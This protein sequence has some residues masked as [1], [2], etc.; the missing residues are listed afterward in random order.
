[1]WH[2]QIICRNNKSYYDHISS[3]FSHISLFHMLYE[4]R[5]CGGLFMYHKLSCVACV[6]VYAKSSYNSWN[7]NYVCFFSPVYDFCGLHWFLFREYRF[8]SK[9]NEQVKKYVFND[10]YHISEFHHR[11][12]HVHASYRVHF[13]TKTVEFWNRTENDLL[14]LVYFHIIRVRLETEAV[15]AIFAFF[16]FFFCLSCN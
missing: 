2:I 3:Y 11:I 13:S 15:L 1:M 9:L 16:F 10:G 5:L 12:A 8:C 6:H 4:N 7:R 14:I